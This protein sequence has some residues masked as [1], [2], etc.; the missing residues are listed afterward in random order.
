MATAT[1]FFHPP[2]GGPFRA[3]LWRAVERQGVQAL[4]GVAQGEWIT[5]PAYRKQFSPTSL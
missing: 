4:Q 3:M 5:T 2:S 1:T